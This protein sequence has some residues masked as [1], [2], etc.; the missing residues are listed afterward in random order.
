MA[1]QTLFPVPVVVD[2]RD[3]PIG[4]HVQSRNLR[5]QVRRAVMFDTRVDIPVDYS[6]EMFAE[7]PEH[8]VA[9]I[10]G[11]MMALRRLMG[12]FV[13]GEMVWMSG[14]DFANN[15]GIVLP[16]WDVAG[17]DDHVE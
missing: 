13:F 12:W 3:W 14:S 7:L 10:W 15:F 16:G 5:A 6:P 11:N 17:E 2:E 1:L 4:P 8:V 9:L